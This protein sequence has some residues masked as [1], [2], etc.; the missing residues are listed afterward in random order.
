MRRIG[1]GEYDRFLEAAKECTANRVYPWSIATG[2]QSGQI[3]TDDKG[4]VLFWHFCGFAYIS[5][6][7]GPD[8]L[9][10]VYQEFWEKDTER[11]FVLITDSEFVADYYSDY[12]LL[13]GDASLPQ[14]LGSLVSTKLCQNGSMRLS[15]CSLR[16]DSLILSSEPMHITAYLSI[17][18]RQRSIMSRQ[19][20]RIQNLFR[21]HTFPRLT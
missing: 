10:E 8:F 20:I 3:Y 18:T 2:I 6:P 1:I 12:D 19:T 11:R 16:A 17:E 7:V 5:G 9:E 4:S 13:R 14:C 15:D 21:C